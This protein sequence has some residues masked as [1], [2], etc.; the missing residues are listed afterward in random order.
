MRD[1]EPKLAKHYSEKLGKPATVECQSIAMVFGATLDEVPRLI[2]T[3]KA[4]KS[5]YRKGKETSF[6]CAFCPVCGKPVKAQENA[7]V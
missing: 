2:Y 7:P 1:L 4:D 6:M 3:V 5:G